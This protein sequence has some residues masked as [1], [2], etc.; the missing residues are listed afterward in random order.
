MM[1][2]SSLSPLSRY[3]RYSIKMSSRSSVSKDAR[4]FVSFSG[5]SPDLFGGFELGGGKGGLHGVGD[6]TEG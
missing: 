6:F 4:L 2:R 5:I 1:I 3:M